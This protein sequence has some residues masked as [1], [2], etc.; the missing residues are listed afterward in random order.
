MI[1]YDFYNFDPKDFL[2]LDLSTFSSEA[3]RELAYFI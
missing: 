2:T 1:Q 3:I